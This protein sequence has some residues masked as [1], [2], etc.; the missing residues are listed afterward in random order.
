MKKILYVSISIGFLM[1]YS[2]FNFEK[3][4]Q[5]EGLVLDMYEY[6]VPEKLRTKQFKEI[7]TYM[8]G[9]VMFEK[10]YDSM[11]FLEADE[12]THFGGELLSRDTFIRYQWYQDV[13]SKRQHLLE[14][15]KF[16]KNMELK[17]YETEKKV[18]LSE[19]TLN[20]RF[21]RVGEHIDST[22]VLQNAQTSPC[23]LEAHYDTLNLYE[24]DILYPRSKKKK[25]KEVL[26][27]ELKRK[28]GESLI[29]K[30]VIMESCKSVDSVTQKYLSKDFGLF[31]LY[32]YPLEKGK[33]LHSSFLY[34]DPSKTR[35]K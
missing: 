27:M 17:W 9:W 25:M 26:S 1:A 15:R 4:N 30:D 18:S 14:F 2:L 6:T 8:A 12:K 32:T 10:D 19:H 33:S 24:I 21:V 28:M 23:K 29:F 11:Q 34:T 31:A 22:A 16:P 7:E 20:K 3:D 5:K 13:S 35:F